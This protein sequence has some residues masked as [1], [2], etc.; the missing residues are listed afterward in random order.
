MSQKHGVKPKFV[1]LSVGIPKNNLSQEGM[2]KILGLNQTTV[3]QWLNGKKK[4]GYDSILL[5]YEKFGVTPN[6]LFG[7]D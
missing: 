5:L 1:L 2:A 6:E 7:I 4:P 3:G